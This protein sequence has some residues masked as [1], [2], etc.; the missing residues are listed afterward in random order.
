MPAPE[1]NVATSARPVPSRLPIEGPSAWVGADMRGREAEWT[2]RLSPREI[3]E[4]ETAM[5]AVHA[6][7]LDIADIR[8]EDFPLPTLGPVLDRLRA[9]RPLVEQLTK[10]PR[11]QESWLGRRSNS[12]SA[13]VGV[14]LLEVEELAPHCA[15]T[16][17]IGFKSSSRDGSEIHFIRTGTSYNLPGANR[18]QKGL[19]P[20]TITLT[21]GTCK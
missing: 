9:L 16:K 21:H 17:A 4:I 3:V 15:R 5:K 8:R 14:R 2:Y 10:G 18:R 20:G 13:G 7:G 11:K 12:N 19:R 1:T 6:R